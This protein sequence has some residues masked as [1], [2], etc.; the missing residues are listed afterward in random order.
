MALPR[1]LIGPAIS[2][3]TRLL[4]STSMSFV[5]LALERW[6]PARFCRAVVEGRGNELCRDRADVDDRHPADPA[7]LHAAGWIADALRS[8][9]RTKRKPRRKPGPPV[10]L[11]NLTQFRT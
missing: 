8:G 10:R 7:L 4:T 2:L 6:L 11:S 1:K 5:G 9:R 3:I